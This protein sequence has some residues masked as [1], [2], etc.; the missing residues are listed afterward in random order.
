LL[1]GR[2]LNEGDSDQSGSVSNTRAAL[3]DRA[4]ALSSMYIL[5]STPVESVGYDSQSQAVTA[6]I[7]LANGTSLN[8]GAGDSGLKEIGVNRHLGG[9]WYIYTFMRSPAGSD[10]RSTAAFLEWVLK[11]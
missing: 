3:A 4:L 8:L 2:K 6:K 11:Y 10:E 9:P 1:F 5:A 7:H